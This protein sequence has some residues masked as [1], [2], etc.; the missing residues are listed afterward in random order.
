MALTLT[1]AMKRTRNLVMR[2]MLKG[3]VTTDEMA[4]VI[5]MVPT[6]GDSVSYFREGTLPDTEFIGDDG[7]A[8][9]EST[10]EDDKTTVPM[11]RIV[12]NMDIDAF[13][14]DLTGDQAG[15][16]RA[17]QTL[18]KTKAT[19]EL[20]KRKLIVGANATGHTLSSS[21]TPFDAITA[22][23][24][25]PGLDSR[26]WGPGN[27]ECDI[28][29]AQR[30]R[31]RAPG[32]T[33]W[34]A[35]VETAADGAYVLYSH[36]RSRYIVVTLDVSL[37]LA[38][39]EAAIR[40]TTTTNDFDGIYELVN[41]SMTVDPVA[42]DGD[43]YDLS[44]LDRLIAM[45]KVRSNR[46]FVMNSLLLERHFDLVRQLGGS[47]ERTIQ[48]PGYNGEVPVYRGI[49]ILTNDNVPTNEVVGATDDAS[50]IILASFDADE[51]LAL[52]CAGGENFNVDADPRSNIV[53]GFRIVDLGERD[54]SD[55]RRIR[56]K[57]YGAPMLRSSL[58][59]AR[60]RGVQS[61][62]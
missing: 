1:E 22:M 6:A 47:N 37:A 50:S 39:G 45:V 43:A 8:T 19:W 14:D 32:D 55:A 11:R 36:N 3:I 49:P 60:R 27:I 13:A 2:G 30:W 9:E 38:D 52:G 42:T 23:A 57:W 58:A 33:Q 5:P 26:R 35:W 46:A 4:A 53:L 59:L 61:A 12:G 28:A 31:F 40:F 15:S 51:G 25:G 7:V 62:A 54:E 20:I 17:M 56:V 44:M 34:G 10:G 29:P 41:P 24:Y 48:L 16:A 18:K 21:A